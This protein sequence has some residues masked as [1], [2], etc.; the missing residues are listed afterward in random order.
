MAA[1]PANHRAYRRPRG[2]SR[3]RTRNQD[4]DAAFSRATDFPGRFP[5]RRGSPAEDC[6]KTADAMIRRWSR[7][8]VMRLGDA[9]MLPSVPE[10]VISEASQ[11]RSCGSEG[12][13]PRVPKS[14]EWGRFPFQNDVARYDS[15]TRGG[16]MDSADR[17]SFPPV[18][19]G[20]FPS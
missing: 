5:A 16:S 2:V 15:R 18:P 13:R 14:L 6:R 4:A 19:V 20:H 7:L 9:E 8:M 11:S 17:R 12:G 3:D 10:P 1:R